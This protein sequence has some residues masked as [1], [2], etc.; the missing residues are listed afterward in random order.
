MF[1]LDDCHFGYIT[2]SLKKFH[3]PFGSPLGKMT[4]YANLYSNTHFI[5]QSHHQ[6]EFMGF[7]FCG[8]EKALV[9]L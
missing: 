1:F 7:E 3:M 5:L 4:K 6:H 9:G 8:W 2:K